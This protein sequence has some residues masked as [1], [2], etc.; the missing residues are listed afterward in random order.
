[1]SKK[2]L[3][4]L[5]HGEFIIFWGTIEEIAKFLNVTEKTV[6]FYQSQVYARRN[7]NGYRVVN[8]GRL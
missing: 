3:Y 4:A 7:Y 2:C 8:T 6:R 1:M 5:Y